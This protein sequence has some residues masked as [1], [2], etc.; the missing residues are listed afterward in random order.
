[1]K[2]E[3]QLL[4]SRCSPRSWG[5]DMNTHDIYLDFQIPRSPQ[6]DGKKLR[7]EDAHAPKWELK[8]HSHG[9]RETGMEQLDS[10]SK[11]KES[12][13]PLNAKQP[14]TKEEQHGAG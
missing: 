13:P 10:K 12:F 2:S 8:D 11:A 1:M 14:R 9:I 7:I 5:C 6:R 3:T 4:S